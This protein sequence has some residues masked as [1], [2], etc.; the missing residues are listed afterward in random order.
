[1]SSE[2]GMKVEVC[3]A[4]TISVPRPGGSFHP[5]RPEV[6]LEGRVEEGETY[7]EAANRLYERAMGIF[8]KH[9]ADQISSTMDRILLV[10]E[11]MMNNDDPAAALREWVRRSM[12]S[13]GAPTKA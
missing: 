5:I 3:V 10:E 9:T 4:Q 6:R 8:V 11:A 1:M 7:E 13:Y 12:E 2:V